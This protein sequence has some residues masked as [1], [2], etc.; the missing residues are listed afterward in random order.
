MKN[1]TY[2][3]TFFENPKNMTFYVFLSCCT[4]F[5][6]HWTKGWPNYHSD[7]SAAGTLGSRRVMTVMIEMKMRIEDAVCCWQLESKRLWFASTLMP[8]KTTD[9]RWVIPTILI[10]W[11]QW[12]FCMSFRQYLLSA[13]AFCSPPIFRPS[14]PLD[15][16]CA[17]QN[18]GIRN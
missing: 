14:V 18:D 2:V 3:F 17:L 15:N 10:G 16:Q 12:L 5:I 6:E 7:V 9:H 4:R 1:Y 13:T 8:A 11:L